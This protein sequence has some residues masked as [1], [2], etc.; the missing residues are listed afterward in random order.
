MSNPGAE[1]LQAL[2]N[3][4]NE[5]TGE[6]NTNLPDAVESLVAGYGQGSGSSLPE[7]TNVVEYE[8]TSSAT[9]FTI[10][11]GLTNPPKTFLIVPVSNKY[12]SYGNGNVYGYYGSMVGTSGVTDYPYKLISNFKKSDGNWDYT[13]SRAGWNV[14]SQNI[15]ISFSSTSVMPIGKYILF[16]KAY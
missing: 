5:I 3:Y 12:D 4:S 11:H 7:E 2:I 9:L 6:S 15:Y 1:A 10:P 16:A 8:V 13:G 14:D